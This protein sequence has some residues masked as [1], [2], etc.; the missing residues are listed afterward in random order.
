MINPSPTPGRLGVPGRSRGRTS[1]A[2][3]SK[4]GSRADRDSP[5]RGPNHGTIRLAAVPACG[6]PIGGWRR[7]RRLSGGLGPWASRSRRN[8]RR[9]A[10]CCRWRRRHSLAVPGSRKPRTPSRIVARG[11]VRRVSSRPAAAAA[12][13]RRQPL[14]DSVPGIPGGRGTG[15]GIPTWNRIPAGVGFRL[16]DRCRHFQQSGAAFPRLQSRAAGVCTVMVVTSHR[17]GG[18]RHGRLVTQSL[19]SLSTQSVTD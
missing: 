1:G 3:P 13:A 6:T 12:R 11:F 2:C 15:R 9:S 14:S 16:S 17:G 19:T 8:P 4:P 5:A 18:R 10:P 7:A